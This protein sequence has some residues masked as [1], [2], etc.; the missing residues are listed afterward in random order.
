MK[1]ADYNYYVNDYH[2]STIS[3]DEYEK[4]AAKAAQYIKRY[5]YDNIGDNDI[6]ECV[7]MCACELADKIYGYDAVINKGIASEK[8]GDLSVNYESSVTIT[9]RTAQEIRV[10]IYTWL[11]GT[12]LLYSGV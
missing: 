3:T 10:I 4:Y 11:T 6:P 8:V 9:A 2:G 12:G 7:K 1:Y 5:T